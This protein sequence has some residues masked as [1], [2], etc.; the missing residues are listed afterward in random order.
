[1]LSSA[2]GNCQKG[3]IEL[4]PASE[5]GRCCISLQKEK[6]ESRL[7]GGTE[8]KKNYEVEKGEKGLG[9]NAHP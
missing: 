4:V 3:G 5:T 8:R 2:P 1:V 9:K 6:R 7:A